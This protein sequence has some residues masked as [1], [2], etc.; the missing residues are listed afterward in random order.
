MHESF[1]AQ[2]ERS[3]SFTSLLPHTAGLVTAPDRHGPRGQR[4]GRQSMDDAW[5]QGWSGSSAPPTTS[6]CPLPVDRGATCRFAR[7]AAAKP[8]SLWLPGGALDARTNCRRHSVG[9]WHL[10]A[11]APCWALVQGHAVESTEAGS[12]CPPA[13]RSR[14]GPVARG[15]LARHSHRI[16]EFLANG[17]SLRLHLERLPAYAPE[18]NP[19]EGVWPQLKG[20]ELRNLCCFTMPHLRRSWRDAVNRVRRTPRLIKSFFR[21]AK[22]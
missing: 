5:P 13:R 1:T 11:P 4:R 20:V 16:R 8:R 19:D 21:G 7:P 17:A 6:W 18:L 22:L 9:I 10:V 12:T 14:D 15:D 2:L 3:P